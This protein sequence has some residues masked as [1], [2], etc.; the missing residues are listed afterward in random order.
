MSNSVCEEKVFNEVHSSHVVSLRNFLFYKSGDLEKA[1]DI[2]QE[3]F[4]RLW[5]NCKKVALDKVK[6]YLF[7]TA[8]R[9]FLDDVDHQKVI[10]KFQH[11]SG[12][13]ESQLEHNPEYLYREGEFKARLEE[14]V[15]SLPEKQRVVFLMSRIDKIKNKDIADQLDISIK[16]VEK[17]LATSISTLKSMLDDLSELKI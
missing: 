10:L 11:R 8:N 14:A 6:S 7:T 2:A 12:M 4:V 3:A 13:S 16:T 17:H 15:S 1:K 9:L 5:N